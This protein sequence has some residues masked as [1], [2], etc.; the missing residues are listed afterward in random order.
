MDVYKTDIVELRCGDNL[1]LLKTLPDN[2][3]DSCVSDFPYNLSFMG[4]K[5]DT[6][7]D[8]YQWCND[9][10]K[11]LYRVLKPGSYCLIFSGTRTQHRMV[12]GFEDAGF[13]VKDQIM[14]VYSQGFPKSFNVSKGFDRKAGAKREVVGRKSGERYKYDFNSD[15]NSVNPTSR[16]GSGDAG[17]LTAPSTDL[18]KKWDGYGT[19]IKPTH[20]PIAIFQKPLDGNYCKNLEKW[21]VG[22]YNIDASRIEIKNGEVVP[23]NK[24]ENWSGFGEHDKPKYEATENTQGRYPANTIFDESVTE[25]LDEQSGIKKGSGKNY[26][27]SG[28]EYGDVNLF[29]IDV[30]PKSNSAIFDS[31]GASRFY[32]VSKAS[33]K[34]RTEDG[35]VDNTHT[36]VKPTDLIKYLIR[37]V[38]P[39]GGICIDI[40]EGSGTA[41]KATLQLCKEEYPVKHLGFE[42]DEFSFEIAV[43]RAELNK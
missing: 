1:E 12:C 19:A 3:I 22:A 21:N 10:A 24:L 16:L 43:K 25:L 38:T 5:W 18:A 30:K 26:N 35:K 23:I 34:D 29:N 28:N 20:E 8:Y 41:S 4:A 15:F 31:G 13:D 6:I 2:S 11:E 36:T 9:R 17:V 14:W 32:Y 42:K 7:K 37:L 39:K 27:Y 40:C 33:Q